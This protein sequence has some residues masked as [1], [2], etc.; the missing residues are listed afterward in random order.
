MASSRLG[1]RPVSNSSY[2][3]LSVFY[4]IRENRAFTLVEVMI[5]MLI[6]VAAVVPVVAL[7]TTNMKET[8]VGEVYNAMMHQSTRI[9]DTLLERAKYSDIIAAAYGSAT[10]TATTEVNVQNL[11]DIMDTTVTPAVPIFQDDL[12]PSTMAAFNAGSFGKS[13]QYAD[14]NRRL[15]PIR[16]TLKIRQMDKTFRYF[17]NSTVATYAPDPMNPAVPDTGKLLISG[18]LMKITLLVE[19]GPAGNEKRYSLVTF[20]AKLED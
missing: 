2:S 1:N 3:K 16:Y 12:N 19:W 10:S 8:N 15:E 11:L 13:W 4:Q 17:I 20:K 5:A 9:L 14:P 18:K 6:M 7:M